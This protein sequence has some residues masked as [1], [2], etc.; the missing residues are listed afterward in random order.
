MAL[1]DMGGLQ[2]NLTTVQSTAG[3][4]SDKVVKMQSQ[5]TSMVCCP[6]TTNQRPI[7]VSHHHLQE[8]AL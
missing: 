2:E 6:E 4:V 7:I 1:R 3:S 8:A 5:V